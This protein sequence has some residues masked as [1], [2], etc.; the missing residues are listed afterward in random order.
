LPSEAVS[1]GMHQYLGVL[2]ILLPVF[3]TM[4]AATDCI[5]GNLYGKLYLHQ[6]LTI[7]QYKADYRKLQDENHRY[8]QHKRPMTCLV[9]P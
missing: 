1:Q 2:Q 6:Y 4:P 3:L 7:K 5:V 8:S 9:T